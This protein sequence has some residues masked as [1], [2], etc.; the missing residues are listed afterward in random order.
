[1]KIQNVMTRDVSACSPEDM[2]S[3]AAQLMWERD[4]GC[5]PVIDH[6]GV[7]CGMVTD[8]DICIA[9]YTQGLPLHQIAVRRAMSPHVQVGLGPQSGGHLHLSGRTSTRLKKGRTPRP[10]CPPAR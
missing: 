6:S 1:M 2:L 4:C 9:A 8:R 10:W 5:V 3:R 7:V